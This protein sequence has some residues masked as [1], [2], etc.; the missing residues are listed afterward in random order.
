MP[1]GNLKTLL[2]S[3]GIKAISIIPIFVKNVFFGF[4]GF[5]NCVSER[6][7]SQEEISILHSLVVSLSASIQREKSEYEIKR[8][9]EMLEQTSN[10]SKVGGWEYNLL[11][12]EVYWTDMTRQILEYPENYLPNSQNYFELYQKGESREKLR[13]A[14]IECIETGKSYDL[15]LLVLTGKGQDKWVRAI[16]QAEFDT[17]GECVRLFGTFQNI[18]EKKRLEERFNFQYEMLSA[19]NELNNY[20]LKHGSIEDKLLFDKMLETILHLTESKFGFIAELLEDEQGKYLKMHALTNIAWSPETQKMYEEMEKS[21]ISFRNFDN[22]FGF[23][24]LNNQPVISN[25]PASDVRRGKT[26]HGHPPLTSFLGIPVEG[27]LGVAG[28]I[29]VANREGGYQTSIIEQLKPF[30]SSY[31]TII[32]AKKEEERRKTSEKKAQLASQA[33]SEFLANMSHE[34]RTPLNGIVGFVDLLQKSKLDI[35]QQQYLSTVH[36][37]ANS[38]LEIV[39]DILDFSKI[40]AGKM[41]L[42]IEK[43]DLFELGRQVADIIKFNAHKKG[44]EILINFPDV[45]PQYIWTD[46]IRLKQILINL[47]SNSV[48]FTQKGEIELKVEL[49]NQISSNQFIFRFSVRDTGIGIALENQQ[50]IFEAFTQEDASITKKF[51][52]TGLG[53]TISNKLL[54]MMN[55]QLQ[56]E[57]ELGKGSIFYFDVEFVVHKGEKP[58]WNKPTPLKNVLIVDDNEGNLK[59]LEEIFL[60]KQIKCELALSGNKA[61]EK[62][63]N[64]SFDLLLMDYQMPKMN[65]LDTI[66]KIR[67]KYP[68][69]TTPIVLLTSSVDDENVEKESKEVGIHHFLLKPI[70]I[71]HLCNSLAKIGDNEFYIEEGLELK[72]IENQEINVLVVEDNS[73]NMLLAKSLLKSISTKISVTEA[74]NGLEAL[75][76]FKRKPFDIIFMDVQMPEMNGYEATMEIRKMEESKKRVPIIAL[77]AGTVKGEKERCLEAGMDDY[78]S[79]PIIKTNVE[80]ILRLWIPKKEFKPMSTKEIV[81]NQQEGYIEESNHFDERNFK[82]ILDNDLELMKEVMLNAKQFLESILPELEKC[83]KSKNQQLLKTSAHYFKGTALTMSFVNLSRFLNDLEHSKLEDEQKIQTLM[84]NAEKEI[85]WL[86]NWLKTGNHFWEGTNN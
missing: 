23:A 24:I 33:K 8:T 2:A 21:G 52:G 14:I 57:S 46:P 45:L 49:L 5:D 69:L 13:E 80:Q 55:S 83:I 51:G 47:M 71:Q 66:K 26:P 16:G 43:A 40:E 10:I 35:I 72:S 9:Q 31:A 4:I 59:I 38:L 34:I 85:F 70:M 42:N 12:N 68:M 62:L 77:T 3:Q 44:L 56:L 67:K 32:Q 78:L 11:N 65:G 22:L 30:T 7:M 37:S 41:E 84:L 74:T 73:V 53:I 86:K 75:E 61:L 1:N 28:M 79:K 81:D 60:L 76:F 64:N 63:E 82:Q 15:E 39:N 58:W 29:A 27:E 25:N 36:Q 19:V 54:D 6:Y 18:D 48:K 17:N 50:K 20:Y